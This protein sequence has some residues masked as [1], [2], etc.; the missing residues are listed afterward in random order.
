[1]F[2]LKKFNQIFSISLHS[3]LESI[4][5]IS[6]MKNYTK[7][8]SVVYF[9]V[10]KKFYFNTEIFRELIE[11]KMKQSKPLPTIFLTVFLDLLGVGL[12]IPI[13]APLLLG[14]ESELFSEST[15][16]ST[17]TIIFGLLMASYSFSQFF[18]SPILGSL[19]DK[20]GR[21]NLMIFSLIA[22]IIGYLLFTIGIHFNSLFLLFLGRIIP[23]LSSGNITIAYSSL[24]DV[25]TPAEKTKN[26]GLVGMAFGL[27]FV[28]GPFIGGH[29]ANNKISSFFSFETPFVF[30][31]L[32][33]I[34]NLYLVYRNF[35]ETLKEK[36]KEEISLFKGIKNI[37]IAFSS[38]KTRRLNVVIFINTLGFAF[39]TQF[40]LVIL[41]DKF[42]FR[43]ENIGTLYGFLG[44]WVAIS[45]GLIIRPLSKRLRPEKIAIFTLP[46]LSLALFLLYF[47]QESFFLYLIIP[48][49]AFS[50]SSSN[51]SLT[52]TVSNLARDDEQGEKLGITLSMNFLAQ[53]IP[54]LIGGA[55]VAKFIYMP[56]FASSGL[57]L[58][59][60]LIFIT[61]YLRTIK[62]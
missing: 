11:G 56:V 10:L 53:S 2:A 54:P 32:L 41:V 16:F 58:I 42:N 21:R 26:F 22:T 38:K 37:I 59:A 28:V 24:A 3:I 29:L 27:G 62:K 31:T 39:F 6:L 4:K 36:K 23:G 33:S 50:Q 30:A 44:L 52:A 45:Q 60:W 49:I 35:P 40:F 48:L 55:L 8:N 57:V 9:P 5:L 20:Y 17:R 25:S 13:L 19:S 34:I 18:S 14:K 47:P 46:L 15:D 43:Q 61:F 51:S 7:S 1:M 12:I